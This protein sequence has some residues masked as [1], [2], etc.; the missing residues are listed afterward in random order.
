MQRTP[1]QPI[2]DWQSVAR[3]DARLQSLPGVWNTT[4]RSFLHGGAPGLIRLRWIIPGERWCDEDGMLSFLDQRVHRQLLRFFLQ[5]VPVMQG[6]QASITDRSRDDSE[7]SSGNLYRLWSTE[8]L[9]QK[10]GASVTLEQLTQ[11]LHFLALQDY[12]FLHDEDQWRGGSAFSSIMNLGPTFEWIVQAH[13]QQTYNALTRRC[14]HFTAWEKLGLN[15]LDVLAFTDDLVMMIECKS[16]QDISP[17]KVARFVRRAQAFPADLALLLIDTASSYQ[18]TKQGEH[19]RS[20]LGLAD[21]TVKGQQ[22]YPESLVL[23]LSESIYVANTADSIQ[24]TLAAII[25]YK[26]A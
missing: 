19:I 17:D 2:I 20:I 15:D 12:I 3:F 13:L 1:Y 25:Q 18:V 21:G 24:K 7:V 14:V 9:R 16:S 8:Q 22:A 23:A 6:I 10:L 26:R 11:A 5:R 4:G